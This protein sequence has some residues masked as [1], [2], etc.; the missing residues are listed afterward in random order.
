MD[1][2]EVTLKTRAVQLVWT[3]ELRE[4][5]IEKNMSAVESDEV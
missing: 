3:N 4:A 5:G 2:V 1:E